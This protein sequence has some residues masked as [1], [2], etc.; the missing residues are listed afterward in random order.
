MTTQEP[1]VTSLT[2][3]APGEEVTVIALASGR[4]TAEHFS[5]LGIQPGMTLRVLQNFGAGPLTVAVGARQ[6]EI[7]RGMAE[8]LL[9]R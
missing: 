6:L 7:G 2:D 8:K 1:D 4:G 5:E 3:V 9:V